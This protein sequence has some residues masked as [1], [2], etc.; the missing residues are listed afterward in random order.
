MNLTG[1]RAVVLFW[2]RQTWLNRGHAQF[3]ED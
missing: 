1:V 2:R 3:R